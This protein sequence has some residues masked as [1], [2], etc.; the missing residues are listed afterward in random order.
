MSE[1]V[2]CQ[3]RAKVAAACRQHLGPLASRFVDRMLATSVRPAGHRERVLRAG[4]MGPQLGR[5]DFELRS[6]AVGHRLIEPRLR[7]VLG[8]ARAKISDLRPDCAV[9]RMVADAAAMAHG[10]R[11]LPGGE[12]RL[13]LGAQGL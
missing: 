13:E 9:L 2:L 3:P 5:S 12:E 1:L 4:Q 6:Q 11:V 10:E 8:D 7:R